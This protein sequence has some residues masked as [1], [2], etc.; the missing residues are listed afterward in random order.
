MEELNKAANKDVVMY[1][2]GNKIDL[3]ERANN[4]RKVTKEEG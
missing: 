2:V 3:V 1:L 4:L